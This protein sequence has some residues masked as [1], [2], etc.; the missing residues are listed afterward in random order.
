[1]F[2]GILKYHVLSFSA[3]MVM[4]IKDSLSTLKMKE[5]VRN[6]LDCAKLKCLKNKVCI[7]YYRL[8]VLHFIFSLSGYSF[9]YL[10][11]ALKNVFNI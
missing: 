2:R 10:S 3:M 8:Y 1:M 7:L 11:K 5:M 9:K 4:D 6:T